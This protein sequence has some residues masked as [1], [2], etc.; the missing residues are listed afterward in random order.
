MTRSPRF[1]YIPSVSNCTTASL[2][3]QAPEIAPDPNSVRIAEIKAEIESNNREI[4][5]LDFLRIINNYNE[6][7]R[8]I[9]NS[10][11]F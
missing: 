1:P 9:H 3:L 4:D 10:Y 6:S 5:Y 2:T 7:L 11:E 8:I